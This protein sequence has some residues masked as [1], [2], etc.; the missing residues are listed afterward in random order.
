MEAGISQ[1]ERDDLAGFPGDGD[2]SYQQADGEGQQAE[3]EGTAAA[4]EAVG[5]EPSGETTP[6]IEVVITQPKTRKP[7]IRESKWLHLRPL[8]EAA[9]QYAEPVGTEEQS[10]VLYRGTPKSHAKVRS[11]V[12]RLESLFFAGYYFTVDPHGDAGDQKGEYVILAH[13]GKRPKRSPK[14]VPAAAPPTE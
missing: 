9:I 10:G 2:P 5:A 12:N 6:T 4:G 3:G 14:T 13:P 11:A 1:L 8:M 7:V